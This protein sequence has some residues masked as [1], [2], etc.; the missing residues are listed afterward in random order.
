MNTEYTYSLAQP[1]QVEEMKSLLW[2]HGQ[3]QW[4]HLP[5][6]EVDEEFE[7]VFVKATPAIVCHNHNVL[8][9]IS[10]IF[11]SNN[12]PNHLGRYD[13]LSSMGYISNVVVHTEHNGK[14]IG[15]G[16][17][18]SSIDV[19]R[20]AGMGVIYIERHEENIG[21]AGMMRKSGFEIVETFYDPERRNSGSCKTSVMNL[22]I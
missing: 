13:D 7:Q 16:L 1:E 3:N 20:Q 17:L 11:I 5:E 22:K 4:N 9:G 12:C 10:T 15:T 21:S 6:V 8:V 18:K 14:G 19:I 2:Q